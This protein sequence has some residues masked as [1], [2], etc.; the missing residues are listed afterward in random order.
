MRWGAGTDLRDRPH[1][2]K[3]LA[4]NRLSLKIQIVSIQLAIGVV[5]SRR[6][7]RIGSGEDE[8]SKGA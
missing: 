1:E 6:A 2:G 7:R 3:I 4:L 5:V 8:I